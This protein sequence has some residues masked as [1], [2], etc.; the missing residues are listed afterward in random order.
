MAWPYTITQSGRNKTLDVAQL[1]RA[2]KLG[3]EPK[4]RYV[5]LYV[6]CFPQFRDLI[7][8]M[9]GATRTCKKVGRRIKVSADAA[10]VRC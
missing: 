8:L 9:S 3:A 7:K 4:F 5:F 10:G 2:K 6:R 1:E